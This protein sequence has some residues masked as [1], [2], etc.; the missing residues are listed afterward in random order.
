MQ[1]GP[2][3][4]LDAVFLSIY[5]NNPE[6]NRIINNVV[7]TFD[8]EVKSGSSI[9]DPISKFYITLL[10]EYLKLDMDF[11]NQSDVDIFLLKFE[12]HPDVKDNPK[13]LTKLGRVI[14]NRDNI[15]SGRLKHLRDKLQRWVVYVSGSR[16]MK[17]V[18][19]TSQ[20]MASSTDPATQDLL[21]SELIE[22][23]RDLTKTYE[24]T[25]LTDET[26]IDMI[27]MTDPDSVRK[28]LEA[29][30]KKR[31]VPGFKMGLQYAGEMFGDAMGP[32]P[33][34]FCGIAALSGD[35]KSGW[36]IKI[37]QWTARLNKPRNTSNGKKSVIAFFSFENEVYENQ[38]M[39]FT[40]A[41]I[42]IH[43]HKPPKDMK[44]EEI[45]AETCKMFGVN[46][47]EFL[48]YREDGDQFGWDEYK[49]RMDWLWE[50]YNVELCVFDYFGLMQLADTGDNPSKRRQEL[51]SKLKNHANRHHMCTWTGFQLDAEAQRI[52]DSGASDP[53][54]EFGPSHIA[55][56]K[57]IKREMDFLM[58]GCIKKNSAGVPFFTAA[59][60]KH[61]YVVTKDIY[62]YFAYPFD[63]ELGLVDDIDGTCTGTR[64]IYTAEVAG[65][66][67]ASNSF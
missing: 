7:T 14:K 8:E 28:G 29:F 35:Y 1:I 49:A 4:F 46:G 32:A 45:I 22:H 41:Y 27:N 5:G 60:A 51:L 50:K 3:F 55:D 54:R 12:Q 38:M 43:G 42:S 40:E 67:G 9:N 26:T 44:D 17:N 64:D 58:F 47:Y 13:L 65:A 24:D 53:V 39:W 6:S 63:P 20:R 25:A 36:L 10:K 34:E 2:D 37:A 52:V 66:S 48:V 15:S 11:D 18:Y 16:Q 21:M 19:K 30:K 59:W 23:A 61:K 33:G 31:S 62:K 56:C 57:G